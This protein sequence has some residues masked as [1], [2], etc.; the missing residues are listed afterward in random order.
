M[1]SVRMC[2][3][4]LVWMST[5]ATG[6]MFGGPYIYGQLG[7]VGMVVLAKYGKPALTSAL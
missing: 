2:N 6:G 4:V 1:E 5:T 3:E 7:S